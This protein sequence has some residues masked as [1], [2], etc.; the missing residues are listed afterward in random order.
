MSK[1]QMDIGFEL[2]QIKQSMEKDKKARDRAEGAFRQIMKQIGK[3]FK[4]KTLEETKKHVAILTKEEA[5][6]RK[7]AEQALKAY[8]SKWDGKLAEEQDDEEEE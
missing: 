1:K 2:L 5:Q 3:E 6:A 7:K 8:H 4:C